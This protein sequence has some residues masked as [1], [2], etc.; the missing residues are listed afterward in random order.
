MSAV[1]IEIAEAV[2][3]ELQAAE[4]SQQFTVERC[5]VPSYDTKVSSDL[6]VFVIGFQ[7]VI[8]DSS[9][10]ADQFQYQINVAVYKR[11]NDILHVAEA[12][13]MMFFTQQVIDLFRQKKTLTNYDACRLVGVTNDPAYDVANMSQHNCFASVIRLDY[14]VLRHIA[15]DD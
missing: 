11:M 4:L 10:G 14:R 2:K 1:L 9:R 8:A 3:A 6:K 12:D 13:E 5:F 15:Q 7:Q